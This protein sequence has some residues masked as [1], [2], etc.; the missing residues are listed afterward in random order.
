MPTLQQIIAEK[1][2]ALLKDKKVSDG[3]IEKIRSALAMTCRL[4]ADHFRLRKRLFQDW[5]LTVFA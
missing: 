5:L 2:L 3:K 1:F 4:S